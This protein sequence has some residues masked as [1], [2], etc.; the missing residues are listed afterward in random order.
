MTQPAKD[1]TEALAALTEH[2]GQAKREAMKPRGAAP[3]ATSAATLPG[4]S[5]GGGGGASDLTEPNYSART[6]WPDKALS[7]SDGIFLVMI[8]PVKQM[9]FQ[10]AGGIEVKHNY[11]EP[12]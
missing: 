6:F 12:T 1:L 5:S 3:A 9:T 10:D 8:K 4:S 7:S 2:Q 11:A